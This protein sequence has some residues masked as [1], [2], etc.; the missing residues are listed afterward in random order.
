MSEGIKDLLSGYKWM[1]FSRLLEEKMISMQRHGEIGTYPGSKGQEA[2]YVG[3]GLKL[4]QNDCYI[5]YYRDQPAL[6]M[7]GYR[8]L[9]IMR[10]WGG[11]ERGNRVGH[12][13]PI[14]VPIATH[15][16]HAAGA[17][18]A[19]KIKQSKDVVLVTIGDGATSKGD[20]YEALNFSGIYQLPILFVINNNRYAISVPLEK[21]SSQVELFKKAD[22]FDIESH[23]VDGL[24]LKTTSESLEYYINKVRSYSQPILLEYKTHRL[25]DH[26]TSDDAKR[27][28]DATVIAKEIAE[29]PLVKVRNT[30]IENKLLN[31]DQDQLLREELNQSIQEDYIQFMNDTIL[32]YKD[33][34][35]HL[36]AA[37]INEPP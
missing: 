33:T 2:L 27:Y 34:K 12:D 20:F 19:L 31:N 28:K 25:C 9:D 35:S 32:N 13:F 6:L 7:R 22:A 21:Q 11:D 5:P 36:Y 15:T 10:Y 16:L 18:Y 17:A 23:Q 24:C 37:N 1:L 14:C 30:L 3:I 4:G 8:P 29:D 26:T